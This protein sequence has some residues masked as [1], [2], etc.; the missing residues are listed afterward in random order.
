MNDKAVEHAISTQ[1]QRRLTLVEV[2]ERNLDPRWEWVVI[3][4]F[5]RVGQERK[6]ETP[7][8]S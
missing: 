6:V 7:S 5:V 2:L 8:Q 4:G 3:N 1:G